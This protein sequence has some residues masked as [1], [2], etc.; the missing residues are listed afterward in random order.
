MRRRTMSLMSEASTGHL[1]V[2]EPLE[3]LES[4]QDSDT[5]LRGYIAIHNTAR[6]P[7]FGG[8]RMRRY[9]NEED[10]FADAARLAEG[11]T[12]K[13]ALAGL[14]FGGGK[15][16]IMEPEFISDRL[17]LFRS[18]GREVARMEGRYITAEDVGTT[19][20]DMRAVHSMTSFVSGIPRAAGFGG[21][22]SRFTA[23]GVMHAMRAAAHP[24]L[25]RH[26][27]EGVQIGVQ[28]LGAVGSQLCGLL[29]AE[30]AQ[31]WVADLDPLRTAVAADEWGARIVSNP[32][33]F[34]M[35][36]DILAPCA[37]GSV[38]NSA[39][40]DGVKARMI[41]G[42]ANNQLATLEDGD[43]LHARGI[44]YLP[45]FLVNAGG[46]IAVAREYLGTGT[47][48]LVH[49]EVR[50]TAMRVEELIRAVRESKY[51]PAR[52][53]IDWAKSLLRS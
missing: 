45:D 51:A 23:L 4:F 1:V 8:C 3:F 20:D 9:R 22:P 39:S 42:A 27:L 37:V 31:L 36:L 53:A 29:V 30:G 40:V 12:L 38:L 33:L 10:A 6:G 47:E 24:I 14:P 41:A 43:R 5:G 18:F 21:D 34:A 49:S 26:G 11:M 28:G 19:P 17:E 52:V 2:G 16:V 7:A 44:W 50:M 15:A 46:I 32:E 13:N 35:E 48:D 25:G